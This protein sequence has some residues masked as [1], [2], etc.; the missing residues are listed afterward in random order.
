M[1]VGP[2]SGEGSHEVARTGTLMAGGTLVSR[3]LGFVRVLLLTYALGLSTNVYDAFNQA[4]QIPNN[5]YELTIGGVLTSVLVP[6]VVAATRMRDHGQRFINKL[7]TLALAGFVLITVALVALTP[8][9]IRITT[10]SGWGEARIQ[11]TIAFAYWC[12]PQVLFY[13]IFALVSGV[14]NAHDLFL[15]SMWTPLINNVVTIAGILAFLW[16]YGADPYG[17]VPISAWGPGRIALLAG[18]ATLGVAI[19]ALL[20]L[21]WWRRLRLPFHLDFDFRGVG[22]RATFMAGIWIF[23][24]VIF[25]QVQK[26]VTS[27]VLS[28]ASN[29]RQ[30]GDI[31]VVANGGFEAMSLVYIL[32]HSV[33]A[34]SL[35][36]IYFTRFSQDHVAADREK[37]RGHLQ[38]ASQ[39]VVLAMAVCATI[40]VVISPAVARMFTPA[41]GAAQV[42][43]VLALL[44]LSLPLMSLVFVYTRALY[45]LGR[46]RYVFLLTA[47]K[48]VW[49]VPAF[50]LLQ[51]LPDS[52][53]APAVALLSVPSMLFDVLGMG[54]VLRRALGASAGGVLLRL[55][56]RLLIPLAGTA[57]AGAIVASLLGVYVTPGFALQ[58]ILTAVLSCLVAAGVMV[59]VFGLLSIVTR[60][61]GIRDL[62]RAILRR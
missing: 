24:S 23:G 55:C 11:L 35:A 9:I 31:T 53:I 5:L 58:S 40:L 17:H 12:V 61:P 25:T 36:T 41:A 6:Q 18:T 43:L 34:V 13:A 21:R 38:S 39:Q 29:G 46:T 44:S 33:I 1:S 27:F 22:L 62:S 14:Y 57:V 2:T 19:Q 48:F 8:W 4:N 7:M 10:S 51:L 28:T 52:L 37:F 50:L 60:V 16:M 45:A 49:L 30:A 54:W 56:G 42:G 59:V 3:I 32:P 20:L 26:L 15:P 47:A